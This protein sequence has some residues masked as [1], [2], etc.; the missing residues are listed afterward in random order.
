MLINNFTLLTI[1]VSLLVCEIPTNARQFSAFHLLSVIVASPTT[2]RT[3]ALCY[4]M[5]LNQ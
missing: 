5:E 3:V 2:I 1:A 4:S